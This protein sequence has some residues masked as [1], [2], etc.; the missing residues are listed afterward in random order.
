MSAKPP[1][2]KP[3]P[4][5]PFAA[6]QDTAA[7]L[8][9]WTQ[10][11]GKIR[12]AQTPWVNHSWH[13]TLY[14]TPR[15]LSTGTI[16]HG[17]QAFSVDFDFVSHEL[18]VLSSTGDDARV[19]LRPCDTAEL[20]AD[21]MGAL[22]GLG[23]AVRINTTPNEIAEPIPFPQDRTNNSYDPA[24]VRRFHR[25]LLDV[26]RVFNEFRA[27]FL[28]KASPVHFFWGSFDLAVTRFSGREAPD[29][30][31]GLPNMPLWVAQEAYSHEVSSAG[32]WPGSRDFPQAIFYSYAYP[33][34]AAFGQENVLPAAATWSEELGEFVLPY[35]AV[36]A[37]DDPDAALRDFLESTFDAAAKT[38][39]WDLDKHRRRH[40]PG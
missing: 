21:L 24:A 28:G 32:F 38:G 12:L 14:V 13:V 22:D 3:W 39:G 2:P 9:L 8:H 33:S 15:G 10:I 23:L 5:L 34:P 20:Y 6:W 17:R 37:A 19:A 35:E 11:V 25:V 16:P 7:T 30:P 4:A 29:H 40:F 18:I 31:G 1:A 36:A 26:N 27:D